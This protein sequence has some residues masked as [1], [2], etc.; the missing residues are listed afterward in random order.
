MS[1]VTAPYE[2]ESE[3]DC[4]SASVASTQWVSSTRGGSKHVNHIRASVAMRH[5]F[6]FL[7]FKHNNKI[8][9]NRFST[10]DAKA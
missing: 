5:R 7:N 9:F 8:S 1:E 6:S 2:I 10:K 3:V 4:G